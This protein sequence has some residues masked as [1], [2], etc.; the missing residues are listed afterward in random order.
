M[1][2]QRILVFG[3]SNVATT[4]GFSV[5]L[6]ERMQTSHPDVEMV[7]VGL[8]ALLPHVVPPYLRVAN[9]LL[10]PF[11]DVL[12]E[13]TSSAYSHS[14]IVTEASGTE[15][16]LDCIHAVAEMGARPSFMLHYR[17]RQGAELLDF[18]GLT[19]KLCA[20]Y[21]IPLLDLAGAMVAEKGVE[22]MNGLLRD[23]AHTGEEGSA[24]FAERGQTFLT[25]ML[26][27]DPKP[28]LDR[29]P[30]PQWRRE[31]MDFSGLMDHMPKAQL[32]CSSLKLP[33]AVF[34]E[35]SRATID[36]GQSHRVMALPFLFHP[37]GGHADLS[38]DGSDPLRLTSIDP[39]SYFTRIGAFGFD[40]Y[41]G[42]EFRT[43]EIGPVSD[44]P[45]V[46]LLRREKTKPTLNYIGA[47]IIM[48]P[49][50]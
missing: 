46:K 32:E 9:E 12:L 21:N 45:D 20:E 7:R 14:R 19:R 3:F 1:S 47:P 28:D 29:V 26:E 11:T 22:Y 50:E 24:L 27:Q 40:F 43:L 48:R 2:K 23:V 49:T 36:L 15:L 37:G 41:R 18:E 5:P 38:V 31:C 16:L 44:A 6:I 34:S 8:G 42:R 10:G 39:V 4:A 35:N 30:L 17:N 13:I 25:Q 33:Y